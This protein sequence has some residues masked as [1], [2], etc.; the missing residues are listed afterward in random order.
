[1]LVDDEFIDR[2]LEGEASGEEAAEFPLGSKYFGEKD[3]CQP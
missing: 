2:I 3:E 1:M